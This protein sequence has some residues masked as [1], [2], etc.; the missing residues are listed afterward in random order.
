MAFD[1]DQQAELIAAEWGVSVDLLNEASWELDTIDGNDGELYGYQ[2]RF[3]DNTDPNLLAELGVEPGNFTRNLSVNAFDEPDGDDETDFDSS[4]PEQVY[5]SD[6][7]GNIITDGRG[8]RIVVG[9]SAPAD[10]QGTIG[11]TVLNEHTIDGPAF[12]GNAFA[13]NAFA[14]DDLIVYAAE[15]TVHSTQ[16][17]RNELTSQLDQLEATFQITDVGLPPRNHNHPPELIEDPLLSSAEY[18]SVMQAITELRSEIRDQQPDSANIVKQASTL[19]KAAIAVMKWIA[20]KADL[21]VDQAIKWGVPL[22]LGYAFTHP[23]EIR[24]KLFKVADTAL[25]WAQHLTP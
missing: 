9:S 18:K 5:L 22:G 12:A 1:E 16:D 7:R 25:T 21:A 11:G 13:G 6:G 17:F 23:V 15:A 14:T 20:R 4:R 2:V 24:D 8:N 19:H 10:T 3:D